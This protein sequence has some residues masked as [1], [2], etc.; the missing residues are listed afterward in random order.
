MPCGAKLW[1]AK[2]WAK[3]VSDTDERV[4]IVTAQGAATPREK[5]LAELHTPLRAM[6]FLARLDAARAAR[7][8]KHAAFDRKDVS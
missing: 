7:D 4:T 5:A 1:V 2:L 6:D 3:D 8:A